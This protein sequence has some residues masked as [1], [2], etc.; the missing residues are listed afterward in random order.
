MSCDTWR[1]PSRV[2]SRPE[3]GR[4]VA[5]FL[6]AMAAEPRGLVAEGEPGIG[7]TTLC[8]STIELAEQRGYRV[9]AARPAEAESV[10][11]YASLSDLLSGVD[12]AVLTDLPRP[13]RLAIDRV[14][15][16]AEAED[17]TTDQRAVGAGFLSVIELLAEK[18]PVLVAIDDLQWL[19]PSSRNVV[20]FAARR[21]SA[22]VG[23]F[24]TVRTDPDDTGTAASWLQLPQ[25][26]GVQRMRIQP[27]SLGGMNAVITQRLGRSLSRPAIVRIQ[28]VSGGNPF[29]AIELARAV[30][31]DVI[32]STDLPIP[33]TLTELVRARIGSLDE[34]SRDALLAMACHAA[35]TVGIVS[36][37]TGMDAE[38]LVARLEHV[39]GKGI[40]GIDGHRLNFAHPLLARGFYTDVTP[41]RRRAM[42][43]RLA[44]IVDE[45]ELKARHL[46]MAATQGDEATLI[47]L[48]EAAD[49]AR[50]RGAPAAA[51]ELLDLAIGLGGDTAERRI[52]SAA[53]HFDAGEPGR[54]RVMLQQ[55]IAELAP[56]PR[57]AEALTLLALVA[58]LNDS[59]DEAAD[60]LERALD[61]VGDE[62][63]QRVAILV[64]LSFALVNAGR[65][66][67]AVQHIEEAVARAADLGEPHALS[68]AL[69]M[70]VMLHFMRGDGFDADSMRQAMVLE[71]GAADVSSAFSPRVQHA[72]V[73]AWVGELD[74]AI[75]EMLAIR[76]RCIDRGEEG[77]LSFIDFHSVLMHLWRG[78]MAEATLIAEDTVERAFQ[79]NGDLPLS[80]GLTVR[81]AVAAYS[82]DEEAV[83]RD[84]AEAIAASERCG[85]R[86][87][88]E[89]PV[90]MLGF[91]E[92][93]LGNY[94]A[95]L[96]TLTPLMG[97][98]EAVPDSTEVIN[99]T[100]LPD[101]AEAL[102]QLGRLEEAE[103]LVSA[104][105]RNG[106]RL[107]RPWM[108]AVGARCRG[109]LLAAQGDVAAATVAVK[110]AITEHDRLPM[111]FER[112]RTLLLSGQ[113]QRRQRQ[114]DQAATTLRE[115]LK[116]FEDLNTPLWADRARAELA[117]ADVGTRRMSSLSPSEQRVAELAASGMTNR[118]VAAALF[119]SPKTVE[120]N[121]ARIYRKLGI[122]SRAELGRH[123]GTSDQ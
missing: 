112:A 17:L 115:A 21:L 41:A 28:E 57:R 36:R 89:W 76:R 59:F 9:L 97:M 107:D 82:G 60:L 70:R 19:D 22:R 12:P 10:L 103:R 58:S 47:A 42:H 64:S 31:A 13:Q 87:L 79:L 93:S 72:L 26:D 104:L 16:R 94:A 7:K 88:G 34:S 74:L 48:D 11:A 54:A 5:A 116:A 110:L 85:S 98:L 39:E 61:G 75:Q 30:D 25:P 50:S 92:L 86:R 71:D 119:I 1:V 101:A 109:M 80:V 4:A 20:A 83:R 37:A 46:A 120:S 77:E 32:R 33:M 6:D 18:S 40:V 52:L 8:L 117:R 45:P 24:G 15:L 114:K 38:D 66:D 90:T 68:Q 43:R 67:A 123:M 62:L 100:Y 35:P 108:K 49:M 84:V 55:A 65:M 99:A 95:A 44:A 2:V 121:L 53:H 27:L 69:G 51:A 102:I 105:E 56:G 96:Q 118:D 29:Y 73:L 81:A 23:V 111:P 113:L 78:S 3:E 14:L 106:Q 122:H 91:L 63:A